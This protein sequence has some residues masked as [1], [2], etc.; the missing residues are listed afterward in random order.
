MTSP[1]KL[2]VFRRFVQPLVLDAGRLT[3]AGVNRYNLDDDAHR[4]F[5]ADG[6]HLLRKHFYLPI[7]EPEDLGESFWARQSE[8]VGDRFVYEE[9]MLA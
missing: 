7:P 4:V 8:M 1:L 6:F 5:D 2:W 3:A 9:D